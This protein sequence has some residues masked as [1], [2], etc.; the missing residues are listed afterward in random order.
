M[1]HKGKI[2]KLT[3]K[4]DRSQ[5][6]HFARMLPPTFLLI[7]LD[8]ARRCSPHRCPTNSKE[9]LLAHHHT[10]SQSQQ[11][12][13]FLTILHHRLAHSLTSFTPSET[14][15]ILILI[16]TLFVVKISRELGYPSL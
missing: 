3:V 15:E 14:F 10:D 1:L 13:A 11:D 16:S 4:D 9:I 2:L 12:R 7:W 6:P 5:H 8:A